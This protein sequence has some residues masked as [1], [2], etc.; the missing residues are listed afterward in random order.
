MNTLSSDSNSSPT[1]KYPS[2]IST[3]SQT[4]SYFSAFCIEQIAGDKKL[5]HFYTG[6]DDFELFMVCFNFLRPCTN[7]LR[8]WSKGMGQRGSQKTHGAHRSLAPLNEFVLVLCR[9]GLLEQDLAFRCGISQPTVS[10]IC[11]TCT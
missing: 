4:P 6:F 3:S 7:H 2:V 1:E 10:R 5:V 11:I 8:Y 9:L